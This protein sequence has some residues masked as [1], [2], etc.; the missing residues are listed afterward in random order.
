MPPV[1]RLWGSTVGFSAFP[2]R[3]PFSYGAWLTLRFRFAFPEGWGLDVDCHSGQ[4]G[5]SG[6]CLPLL[7]SA[8]WEG[9]RFRNQRF[10]QTGTTH[11]YW[12]LTPDAVLVALQEPCLFITQKAVL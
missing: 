5:L 7:Q 2:C 11:A 1:H 9:E 8:N 6:F 4:V 10:H 12:A 3:V